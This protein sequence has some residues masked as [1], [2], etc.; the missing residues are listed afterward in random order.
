[1]RNFETLDLYLTSFLS[2]H[3]CKP[4]LKINNSGRVIFCFPDSENL[5]TLLRDYNSNEP[6]PVMDFV[7]ELKNL[8]GRMMQLRGLSNTRRK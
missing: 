3:D 6:V 8:R 5:Y 4:Q 1:M 7:T 2:F